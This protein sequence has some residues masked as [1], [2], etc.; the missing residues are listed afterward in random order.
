MGINFYILYKIVMVKIHLYT[1]VLKGC[2]TQ[3]KKKRKNINED[4]ENTEE[5]CNVKNFNEKYYG[6]E[7]E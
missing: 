2:K 1:D 7:K 4:E 6:R 3:K 5:K